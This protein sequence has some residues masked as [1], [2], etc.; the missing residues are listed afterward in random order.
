MRSGTEA[1]RLKM[2]IA[3]PDFFSIPL[4]RVEI[5]TVRETGRTY[6]IHRG[7]IVAVAKRGGSIDDED[8]VRGRV[9]DRLC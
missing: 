2:E 8:T 6:F 3:A 7:A 4:K 1:P 5:E 9:G